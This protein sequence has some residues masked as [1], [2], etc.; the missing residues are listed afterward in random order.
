MTRISLQIRAIDIRIYYSYSYS[1]LKKLKIW[2]LIWRVLISKSL[3]QHHLFHNI[4]T[5]FNRH[6]LE[7]T[8]ALTIVDRDGGN[9]MTQLKKN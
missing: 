3:M 6:P 4:V 9:L 7:Q 5:E 2:P 8:T 1:S